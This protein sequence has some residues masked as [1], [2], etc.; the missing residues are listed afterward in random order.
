MAWGRITLWQLE[1][2]N[3]ANSMLIECKG[4]RNKFWFPKGSWKGVGLLK[5]R[6]KTKHPPCQRKRKAPP[7]FLESGWKTRLPES[8]VRKQELAWRRPV[9]PRG[10]R[11]DTKRACS[12][13]APTSNPILPPRHYLQLQ[14]AGRTPPLPHL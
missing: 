10:N 13:E 3:I 6:P 2:V 1:I 12:W 4:I 5:L 8:G 9:V 11:R 7:P 14:R